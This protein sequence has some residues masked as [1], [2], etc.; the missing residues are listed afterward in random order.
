MS[1]ITLSASEST[2]ITSVQPEYDYVYIRAQQNYFN[3]RLK[4]RGFVTLN[5]V[6]EALGFLPDKA[7]LCSGWAADDFIEVFYDVDKRSIKIAGFSDLHEKL[8]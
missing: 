7:G 1:T 3:D 6:R 8:G 2:E 5:E 4:I